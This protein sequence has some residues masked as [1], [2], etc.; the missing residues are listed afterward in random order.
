MCGRRELAELLKLRYMLNKDQERKAKAIKD[1]KFGER[2]E[3]EKTQ[4]ELEAEVDK[5]LEEAIKR[6]ER[7][8]KRQIK[9]DRE[10]DAKHDLRKKM[11]V[12]AATSI[13]NDDDLMLDKKTWD[14]LKK[15]D[16]EEAHKFLPKEMDTESEEDPLEK[17]FKFLTDGGVDKVAKEIQDYSD[18]ES[19]QDEKAKRINKMAYEIE[20]FDKQQKEYQMVADKKTAKKDRKNKALIELQRQKKMDESDDEKIENKDI[21]GAEESSENDEDL[22]EEREILRVAKELK[23][24]K[25]EHKEDE[26]EKQL[27]LNPLLAMQQAKKTIEGATGA[28]DSE[29]VNDSEAWSDDDKYEPKETKDEKK[30]R[31]N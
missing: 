16:I 23:R 17:K 24:Q 8:K 27:F 25:K 29:D 9:K 26:E 11:S 18:E 12:I 22:E 28:S 3:V 19:E 31:L 5:E 10:R 7:D 4:E 30:E 13:N 2:V 21:I 6:L 14:K 20:A 1:A 15:I